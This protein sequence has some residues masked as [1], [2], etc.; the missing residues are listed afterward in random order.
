ML[1]TRALIYQ[2]VLGRQWDR[3]DQGSQ[4]D[5]EAQQ[6]RVVR[7]SPQYQSQLEM[8]DGH[9]LR[10]KTLWLSFGLETDAH[11]VLTWSDDFTRRTWFT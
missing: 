5:L 6:A 7:G 8:K 10:S 1:Y 3:T 9:K 11:L 2:V 4:Q